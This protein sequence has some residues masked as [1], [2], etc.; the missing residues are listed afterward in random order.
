VVEVKI[1][2]SGVA[3]FRFMR[4]R[5]VESLTGLSRSTLY[6]MIAR[7]DFP[8]PVRIAQGAVGWPEPDVL[9]WQ[10]ERIAE[11]DAALTEAG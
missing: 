6:A 7:G 8:R 10:Q 2:Q 4:R 1:A 3:G 11:R 9:A 5:E